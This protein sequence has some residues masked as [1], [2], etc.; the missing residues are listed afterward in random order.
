MMGI[1]RMPVGGHVGDRCRRS[2]SEWPGGL[3]GELESAKAGNEHGAMV[4]EGDE[5]LVA[6]VDEH[7]RGGELEDL[8]VLVAV[9]EQ[10]VRGLQT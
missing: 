7:V 3:L 6:E 8:V 2:R 9:G 4:V 10:W 5:E 1:T